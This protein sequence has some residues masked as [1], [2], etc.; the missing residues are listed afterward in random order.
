MLHYWFDLICTLMFP[1]F[2]GIGQGPSSGEET[3][4]NNLLATSEFATGLGSSDLSE[5][6]NFWSSILSGNMSQISAVLAP[7]IGAITGAAQANIDTTG[8][9]GNRSGGTNA[10]IQNTTNNTRGQIGNLI[11]GL[12]GTAATNL[13]NL[14]SSTLA[15]GVDAEA[16]AFGA[17]KTLHDQSASVWDDIFNSIGQIAYTAAT[18]GEDDD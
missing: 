10:S 8:Q 12:T 18:A 14:G 17:Q 11:G 1:M 13:G 4:A 3:T 2:F 9:F 15:T 16:E 6:S 7:Q 5:A